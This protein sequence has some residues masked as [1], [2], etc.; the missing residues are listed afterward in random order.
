[1]FFSGS[2]TNAENIMYFAAGV[3]TVAAFTNNPTAKVIERAKQ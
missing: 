2:G 3:G 1:L